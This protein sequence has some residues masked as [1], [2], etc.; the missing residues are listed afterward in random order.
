MAT[1]LTMMVCCCSVPVTT[2]I[3]P[4]RP[5]RQY[6]VLTATCSADDADDVA[7]VLFFHYR[8]DLT[9]VTCS[10]VAFILPDLCAWRR[11]TVNVT[12]HCRTTCVRRYPDLP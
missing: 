8:V 5:L 1:A 11:G 7:A 12:E 2:H 6:T 4:A 10:F 3:K 9:A